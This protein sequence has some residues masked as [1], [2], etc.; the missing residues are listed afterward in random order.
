MKCYF[1]LFVGII[2]ILSGCFQS[3]SSRHRTKVSLQDSAQLIVDQSIINHGGPLLDRSKVEFVFRDRLYKVER[4]FGVFKY[5]RIFKDS[6]GAEIH[7]I[8]GNGFFDRKIDGVLK[9]VSM[10]DSAK[11]S[12]ALNSVIYFALLPYF[13]KDE[14]VVKKYLGEVVIKGH[15]YYKISVTFRQDGGGKDFQDEYIYW[16]HKQEQTLDYFAYNYQVDGGG[17]R[18]RQ[19]Y[20]R[21]RINGI[22]IADY[23]NYQPVSGSMEVETFDQLLESGGMKELSKIEFHDIKVMPL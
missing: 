8:M 22:L 9:V 1:F 18:M 2:L 14:A 12:D 21:R 7:D 3:N 6:T 10:E 20:N 5:E 16:F 17:S 11:Y 23:I 19:A 4:Q 13:L 15:S